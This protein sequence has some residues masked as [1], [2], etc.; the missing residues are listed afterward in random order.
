M[1]G[2]SDISDGCLRTWGKVFNQIVYDGEFA[3][4]GGEILGQYVVINGWV[5]K[6]WGGVSGER[7][8]LN[9]SKLSRVPLLWN[10]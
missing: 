5:G 4:G 3:P 6:R 10:D 9:D 7:E 8:I 1:V 2:F